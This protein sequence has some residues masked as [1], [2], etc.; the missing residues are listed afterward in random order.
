MRCRRATSAS[1]ARSWAPPAGVDVVEFPDSVKI[2]GSIQLPETKKR[3]VFKADAEVGYF[4][5]EKDAQ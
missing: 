2:A 5:G 1:A 3:F 4:D